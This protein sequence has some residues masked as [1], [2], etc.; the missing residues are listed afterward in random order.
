MFSHPNDEYVWD[1]FGDARDDGGLE[2]EEL[3]R[4]GYDLLGVFKKRCRK[5]VARINVFVG[6]IIEEHRMKRLPKCTKHASPHLDI[7]IY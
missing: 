6:K 2:L 1:E 7:A 3:V 5:L 4:E